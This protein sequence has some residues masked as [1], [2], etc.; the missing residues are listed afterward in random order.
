MSST[1]TYYQLDTPEKWTGGY[2]GSDNTP[3][4]YPCGDCGAKEPL[5]TGFL[6][7]GP[8]YLDIVVLGDT[9][10]YRLAVFCNACWQKRLQEVQ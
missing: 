10:P 9:F 7:G 2:G 4:Y 5:I 6:A 3:F 1:L 8:E